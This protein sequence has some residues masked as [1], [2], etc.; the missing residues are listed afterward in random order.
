MPVSNSVADKTADTNEQLFDLIE[1]LTRR[2]QNGESFDIEEYAQ[3]HPRFAEKIRKLSGT[4]AALSDLAR[5]S[6]G[7]LSGVADFDIH[8]PEAERRTLGDYCILREIARGGMGVVYE[9]EQLSIRRRVALK[10][11]PFATMLD[12]T[13]LKRF[14]NEVSAAAQLDH[15]NIV[16]I[17]AVGCERGVHHYAMRLIEGCTLADL[18]GRLRLMRHKGQVLNNSLSLMDQAATI[19][20]AETVRGQA[21]KKTIKI[22]ATSAHFRSIAEFGEAIA[23]ALEHA[24]QNGIVHRDIKPSNLMLEEDGH[25]WVTDFG[26]AQVE[27]GTALTMTGDLLG[28]I[29]Y[30]SPEQ[31][32]GRRVV[33]DHRTDIYSLGVTLYELL[34]LQPLFDGEDRKELLKQIALAEPV[35]LRKLN[36]SIPRELETVIHKAIRKDPDERYQS[37]IE[38]ADDLRR[39]LEDKPILAKPPGVAKRV[40][41]WSK[42]HA[43]LLTVAV[44]VLATICIILTVAMFS[45]SSAR[46]ESARQRRIVEQDFRASQMVLNEVIEYL[47]NNDTNNQTVSASARQELLKS[48]LEYY[49]A[50]LGRERAKDQMLPDLALAHY[51]LGVI[52]SKIGS[53]LSAREAYEQSSVLYL[54]LLANEP[55]NEEYRMIASQ[56]LG[57]TAHKASQFFRPVEASGYAQQ[58]MDLML[59]GFSEASSWD[60]RV[61]L[62]NILNLNSRSSADPVGRLELAHS[63]V[64]LLRDVPKNRPGL[65]NRLGGS[66]MNLAKAQRASGDLESAFKTIDQAIEIFE[67]LAPLANGPSVIPSGDQM[68]NVLDNLAVAHH[69]LGSFYTQDSEFDLAKHHLD[70]SLQM[71]TRIASNQPENRTHLHQLSWIQRK[72]ARLEQKRNR[73]DAAVEHFVLAL[74]HYSAKRSNGEDDTHQE[75][76]W[77]LLAI[78]T[79]RAKRA[80]KQ[81]DEAVFLMQRGVDALERSIT[82][83]AQ[84]AAE[85]ERLE[86]AIAQLENAARALDQWLDDDDSTANLS[87]SEDRSSSNR[88]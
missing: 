6:D 10:I 25:A 76:E 77:A 2:H 61:K 3:L 30:M 87:F 80:A 84:L 63:S 23:G 54:N 50:F 27:T 12:K 46:Q 29:R 40:S 59:D 20:D 78:E 83:M 51:H 32:L 5:S 37:A 68:G 36:P 16:D 18:I 62:A 1:E 14:Q 24:H 47:Q 67:D 88:K 9:A 45:I 85:P 79:A 69:T 19:A 35:A 74:E 42:R 66:L 81:S 73:P 70:T 33:L 17:F 43:G 15:P 7:I 8:S 60:Y 58:A 57:R 28:T 82:Q 22:A 21:T 53:D 11:L 48:C 56:A 34:A 26:L 72:L 41:K 64:N 49:R 38:I 55:D 71:Y 86:S 75:Y 13:T 52:E 39:Y 4:L 65:W 31:A 44:G